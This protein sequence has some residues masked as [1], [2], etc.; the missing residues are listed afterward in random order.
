MR[1]MSRNACI[2]PTAKYKL[3]QIAFLQLRPAL[4]PMWIQTGLSW[5][6]AGKPTDVKQLGEVKLE[7]KHTMSV[8]HVTLKTWVT[9]A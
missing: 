2:T 5:F 6:A 4:I 7:V 1:N 3:N 8:E 9:R